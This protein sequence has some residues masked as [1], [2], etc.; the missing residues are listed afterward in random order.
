MSKIRFAVVFPVLMVCTAF[1]VARWENYVQSKQPPKREYPFIPTA[2]LV[3]E[4]VNAP[5]LLFSKLC[6]EFLPVYRITHTP[7]S[8]LGIGLEQTLF[9]VGVIALW[10]LVGL[11]IDRRGRPQPASQHKMTYVS[12][13]LG[14][15]QGAVGITLFYLGLIPFKN[16][17]NSMNPF[18]DVTKGVLFLVW[19]ILLMLLCG[20]A[21]ARR[22]RAGSASA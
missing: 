5:A 17:R 9:L 15:V 8:F 14:T 2:T 20:R 4:G 18:G 1:P 10:S 11:R 19:A 3:Y 21:V 7:V 13:L 16:P 12:V 6:I 22:L